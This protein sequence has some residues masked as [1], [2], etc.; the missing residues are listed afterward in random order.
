MR[1]IRHMLSHIEV[2]AQAARENPELADLYRQ[3]CDL[4][5]L[6]LFAKD[7]QRGCD[8]MG[9]VNNLKEEFSL[10][11]G[12]MVTYCREHTIITDTGPLDTDVVLDDIAGRLGA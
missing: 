5:M 2:I 7:R 9:E 8:G 1:G 11:I 12:T 3:T 10:A 6:Y 4:A